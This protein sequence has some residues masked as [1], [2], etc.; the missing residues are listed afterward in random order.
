MKSVAWSLPVR[1]EMLQLMKKMSAKMLI[2]WS[3]E[4]NHSK[5]ENATKCLNKS[6]WYLLKH[7]YFIL[8]SRIFVIPVYIFNGRKQTLVDTSGYCQ[9]CACVVCM[10]SASSWPNCVSRVA[11]IVWTHQYIIS[12]YKKGILI[13][14]ERIIDRRTRR[15]K[16]GHLCRFIQRREREKN[17]CRGW[18]DKHLVLPNE[19]SIEQGALLSFLIPLDRT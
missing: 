19:R 7:A 6:W 9:R 2:L 17:T 18:V 15:R 14:W 4:I 8:N 3:D 5:F 13:T 16:N 10:T 11:R 12:Y 1:I